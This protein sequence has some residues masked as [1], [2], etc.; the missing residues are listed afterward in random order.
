[1]TLLAASHAGAGRTM[2]SIQFRFIVKLFRGPLQWPVLVVFICLFLHLV[3]MLLQA[4][5]CHACPTGCEDDA[6]VVLP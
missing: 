6:N 2:N 1:M 5:P 3:N 4:C